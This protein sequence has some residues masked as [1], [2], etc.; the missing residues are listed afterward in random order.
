MAVGTKAGSNGADTM[1]VLTPFKL[2]T[3]EVPIV[4]TSELIVHNWSQKAKTMMLDKQM[5]KTRQKKEPKVPED[6]YEGSLYKMPDGDG[7]GF[8]APGFKAAMVGACRN[9]S[10]LPMTVAKVAIRVNGEKNGPL[11]R[12][13]GEPRMREDMVRLETGVA[14]L[15]YRAGFREWRAMLSI[16]FNAGMLTEGNVV[17]LVAAAGFGGIGDWRPSAP[18]SASGTYGTFEVQTTE[19]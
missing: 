12:I 9:F 17:D 14:D 16:T 1:V 15:R 6:D 13:Y 5:G 19:P 4:G 10:G 7:Y 11:V 3:I 8:P 2:K 18:K